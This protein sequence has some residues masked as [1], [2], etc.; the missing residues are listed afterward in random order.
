M[1]RLLCVFLD[2]ISSLFLL[3][4]CF[5]HETWSC[6]ARSLNPSISLS[7]RTGILV[8]ITCISKTCLEVWCTFAKKMYALI[9]LLNIIPLA[10]GFTVNKK[11][12]KGNSGSYHEA[13]G[14]GRSAGSER[15]ERPPASTRLS[16]DQPGLT[17]PSFP[18]SEFNKRP[19]SLHLSSHQIVYIYGC[20]STT[21]RSICT[22]PLLKTPELA[23]E[24]RNKYT[25][26]AYNTF[27]RPALL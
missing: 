23:P 26:T 1:Q 12:K 10:R 25:F 21:V 16:Y 13:W 7:L 2:P 3:P 19:F 24:K 4:F 15:S 11:K 22:S 20:P 27:I 5:I 6:C 17:C 18:Q 8:L 14:N 9:R